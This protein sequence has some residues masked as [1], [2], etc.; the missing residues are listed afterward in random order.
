M[1]IRTTP[2]PMQLWLWL[3]MFVC[4]LSV[5]GLV[6]WGMFISRLE[7]R[8]KIF[9]VAIALLFVPLISVLVSW[10]SLL[11]SGLQGT[12]TGFAYQMAIQGC[13]VILFAVMAT[14][15][16]SMWMNQKAGRVALAGVALVFAISGNAV[17]SRLYNQVCP[18]F[19][20]AGSD[21][22]N[23]RLVPDRGYAAFTDV[24]SAV[25]LYRCESMDLN[26][27]SMPQERDYGFGDRVMRISTP[28]TEANCHGWVFTEGKFLMRGND[29]QKI[30]AD[31]RYRRVAKPVPGD[32]IIYRDAM[33]NILH[34]GVVR[35]IN[36]T[37]EPFV[38]SKWGIQGHFLHRPQDQIYSQYYTYY[39]TE[40]P[41]HV[42]NVVKPAETGLAAD[43]TSPRNPGVRTA[44]SVPADA[45][46]V[47][48]TK[49]AEIQ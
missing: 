21:D 8:R 14:L 3:S 34:T 17:G 48:Q 23:F 29:V 26:Q 46:L 47:P 20:S 39:H 12:M 36:E 7:T 25:M 30:L 42:I 32:L 31:H 24:G 5:A 2:E 45:A 49:P 37:G 33:G 10:T 44:G 16:R 27:A 28:N 13:G 35:Y 22:S 19:W 15:V 4:W 18:D 43:W 9:S 40:R 11:S 38:E 41:S 6:V 1:D